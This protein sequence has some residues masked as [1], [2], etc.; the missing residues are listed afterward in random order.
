MIS[1]LPSLAFPTMRQKV[2]VFY[3]TISLRTEC[4]KF[5]VDT[6]RFKKP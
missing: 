4:D 2:H 1:K 3:R 6:V 5:I